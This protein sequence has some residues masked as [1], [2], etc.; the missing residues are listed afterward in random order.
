MSRSPECESAHMQADRA[1]RLHIHACSPAPRCS[2]H[3]LY[4]LLFKG[5]THKQWDK[6]PEQL[7]PSVL[8]R[9][10]GV[11]CRRRYRA[12]LEGARRGR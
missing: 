1:C 9:I 5:Y 4:D 12:C 11:S 8:A 2:G 10:P 6:W 7:E 3:R